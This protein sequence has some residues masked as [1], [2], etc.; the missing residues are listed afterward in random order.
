MSNRTSWINLTFSRR[1][2]YQLK[3]GNNT[4]NWNNTK[5][6]FLRNKT[7]T[8]NFFFPAPSQVV[9]NPFHLF[10]FSARSESS[11]VQVVSRASAK[12]HAKFGYL[13]NGIVLRA[14][15]YSNISDGRDGN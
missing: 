4:R 6:T 7:H 14:W 3:T 5:I 2:S 1:Q 11:C 13:T 9:P 12:S 15:A 10:F 8:V